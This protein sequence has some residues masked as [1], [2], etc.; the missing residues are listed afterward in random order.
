MREPT[1]PTCL[2]GCRDDDG[3][4]V[5]TRDSKWQV[6]DECHKRLRRWL[7]DIPVLYALLPHVLEPGSVDPQPGGH[8]GKRAHPPIPIRPDVAD[9]RDE[10]R[11]GRDDEARGVLGAVEGWARMLRYERDIAPPRDRATVAGETMLLLVH[12]DWIAQQRWADECMAELKQVH[13]ALSHAC[14][15]HGAKPVAVCHTLTE[16]GECGGPILPTK[17]G[18][19]AR[20]G[21]CGRY[22]GENELARLGLVEAS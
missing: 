10:R 3:N 12:S 21:K 14:G 1:G 4:H 16:D 19:G 15:E 8:G 9:L 17:I 18:F 2:N 20:C 11:D 6:C 13:R 7:A 5:R 22:W